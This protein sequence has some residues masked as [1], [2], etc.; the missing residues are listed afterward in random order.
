MPVSLAVREAGGEEAGE[1]ASDGPV[2]AV[3]GGGP[4]GGFGGSAE[5]W[6]TLLRGVSQHTQCSTL[7]LARGR[8]C[9]P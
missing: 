1:L 4:G 5:G 3:P 9:P 2:D 6:L 8:P 7:R